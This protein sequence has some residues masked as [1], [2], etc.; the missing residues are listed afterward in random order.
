LI[1]FNNVYVIDNYDKYDNEYKIYKNDLF[2][3]SKICSDDYLHLNF[4]G[5]YYPLDF[6]KLGIKRIQ[7][8]IAINIGLEDGIEPAISRENIRYT[9]EAKEFILNKIKLIAEWFVNEY[10]KDVKEFN[11]FTEAKPYIDSSGY[12]VKLGEKDI[13]IDDIT[14]YSSIPFSNITVKGYNNTDLKLLSNKY[15]KILDT[16]E[17]VAEIDYGGRLNTKNVSRSI[18]YVTNPILVNS[19]PVG[20]MREYLKDKYSR[21]RKFFKMKRPFTLKKTYYSN[22]DNWIHALNLSDKPKNTWRLLIQDAL[23]IQQEWIAKCD[24]QRNLEIPKEWLEARKQKRA[25]EGKLL[26]K[27]DGEITYFFTR[28]KEYGG[29]MFDKKTVKISSL[30]KE[31]KMI[32]YFT[33]QEKEVA[34]QKWEQIF[35]P[36]NKKYVEIVLINSR[37]KKH[38]KNLQNYKTWKEYMETNQFK[39]IATK[40]LAK[41]VESRYQNIL[42]TKEFSTIMETVASNKKDVMDRINTYIQDV[43]GSVSEYA[44]EDL[45]KTC[46]ENNLW[47]MGILSDIKEMEKLAKQFEFINFMQIPSRYAEEES[48]KKFAKYVAQYILFNKLYKNDFEQFEI[49]VKAPLEENVIVNEGEIIPENLIEA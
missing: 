9:I 47:D 25:Y 49:C 3:Y 12:Y 6:D 16:F 15:G 42:R 28:N 48:K 34:L 20:N 40:M 32:I 38:V 39:K 35:Y 31:K 26:N 43:Y 33:P 21:N 17:S 5:I 19:T 1:Y 27:Q 44:L 18:E 37:E 22:Y 23:R 46:E 7:V 41:K 10:N 14:S 4:A 36:L 30:G 11:S 45:L 29:Q 24:D 13:K 2:S 8:P